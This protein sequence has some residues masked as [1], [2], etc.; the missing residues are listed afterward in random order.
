MIQ[1]MLE[2]L[3][4]RDYY[5]HMDGFHPLEVNARMY[6]I[7]DKYRVCHLKDFAIHK[8]LV[9]LDDLVLSADLLPHFLKAVEIIY[10]SNTS[11]DRGLHDQLVPVFRANRFALRDHEGFMALIKSDLGNNGLVDDFIRVF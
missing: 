4:Q 1:C 3:Y 9:A 5:D 11:S 2:F 8:F 7:A 6:S 10:S